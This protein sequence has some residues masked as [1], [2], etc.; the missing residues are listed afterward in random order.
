M[1]GMYTE[2]GILY[3]KYK[4]DRLHDFI[5]MNTKKFNIPKLIRACEKFYLWKE[6][7]YL[8]VHYDEHD[9]A[10]NT[11]MQHSDIAWTHEE[12]CVVM[13]KVSNFEIFYRAIVFYLEEHALELCGL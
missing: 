6:A 10:A 9:S 13:Q 8:Y 3:A 4:P 2:L 11:M 1:G 7:V 12:F 5:K